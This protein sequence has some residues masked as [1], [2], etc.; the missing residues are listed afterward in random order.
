MLGLGPCSQR[1]SEFNKGF[2]GKLIKRLVELLRPYAWAAP[3]ALVNA[4]IARP[5]STSF[6]LPAFIA[7]LDRCSD[8]HCSFI[9]LHI[10]RET[11]RQGFLQRRLPERARTLWS[12][13]DGGI[14]DTTPAA[15]AARGQNMVHSPKFMGA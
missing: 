11:P 10:Q 8:R 6:P 14:A 3:S 2:G 15:A 13:L 5:K 1:N 4:R 9:Y 7:A 12:L